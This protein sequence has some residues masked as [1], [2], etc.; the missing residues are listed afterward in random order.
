MGSRLPARGGPPHLL[1]R[2]SQWR[3]EGGL[4]PRLRPV[5]AGQGGTRKQNNKASYDFPGPGSEGPDDG[6]LV[7]L[8]VVQLKG[9]QIGA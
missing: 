7:R 3:D 5:T 1:E 2:L 6:R 8:D 4:C 9:F